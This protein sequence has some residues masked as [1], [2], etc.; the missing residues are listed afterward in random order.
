MSSLTAKPEN[1]NSAVLARVREPDRDR[2]VC[3]FTEGHGELLRFSAGVF[4]PILCPRPLKASS[5]DI[6][7]DETRISLKEMY[8]KYVMHLPREWRHAVFERV[9]ELFSEDE[10]EE[11]ES[12][13]NMGSWETFLRLLV[14]LKLKKLPSIGF[15]N[16]YFSGVWVHSDIRMTIVCRPF[17]HIEWVCSRDGEG[18]R[19]VTAGDAPLHRMRAL[20]QSY[21]DERWLYD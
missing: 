4:S 20:L 14:F 2:I 7:L 15:H 13:P 1:K 6:S 16:G 11:D 17:D 3:R 5:S 18:E 19:E 8:S 21:N 9:D 12:Q 10:W